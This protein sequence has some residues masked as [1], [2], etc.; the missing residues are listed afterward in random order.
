MKVAVLG[1]TGK[2]GRNLGRLL[3]KK[4]QIIIASR[5]AR[6]G[7]EAAKAIPGAT[8]SDYV[9][10]ATECEAAIFAI[11]FSA[12][13]EAAPLAEALAGKLVISI[14]NPIES[15]G[16]VLT[17]PLESG[18]AAEMLAAMLPESRVATAF[19]NVPDSML[20]QDDRPQADIL[21]AT[22]SKEAY[23]EV[24]ALVASVP[25]MRP[26]HAGPLSSARIVEE[27]TV[28]E[29]NVAKRNGKSRLAPRFVSREG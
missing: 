7:R 1:G 27:L 8:G 19:N 12:I 26:L 25:G 18:S 2:M 13:G 10:A 20:A 14:I 17:Y 11:P 6:R 22:D 15:E 21:V 5:D 24:A 28:F 23:D 29:L 3:S 9:G 4:H 16:G